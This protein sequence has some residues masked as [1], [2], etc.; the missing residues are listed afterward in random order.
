MWGWLPPITGFPFPRRQP[1]PPPNGPQLSL[2]PPRVASC[3]ETPT[4]HGPVI[5][6]VR[7]G[8]ETVDLL[9]S[10]SGNKP[11]TIY[12]ANAEVQQFMSL[13]TPSLAVFTG[14]IPVSYTYDIQLPFHP[15]ARQVV[16]A[17]LSESVPSSS[18]DNTDR[19]DLAY[20]LP[21]GGGAYIYLYRL[22]I[23]FMNTTGTTVS[24]IEVLISLPRDP[25]LSN[26]YASDN[27]SELCRFLALSGTR[28]QAMTAI[29][30]S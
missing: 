17:S 19:F 26:K 3:A 22:R 10:N 27:R 5:A 13:P 21:H 20:T 7:L 6:G 18:T 11:A 2:D 9:F 29:S 8:P 4:C 1:T 16:P 28:S 12:G 14:H 24:P 15:A 30:P 23:S 25:S